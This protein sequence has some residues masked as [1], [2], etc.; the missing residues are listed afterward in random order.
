MNLPIELINRILSYRQCHPVATMI[1]TK[2]EEYYEEDLDYYGQFRSQYSGDRK[3]YI[4]EFTSF[5]EWTFMCINRDRAI[6][7]L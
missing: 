6:K 5:I 4:H 2:I 3:L 1:K 7:L